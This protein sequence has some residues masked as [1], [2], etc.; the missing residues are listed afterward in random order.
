MASISTTLTSREALEAWL[1]DFHKTTASLNAELTTDTF[2]TSDAE[3][4][5]GNFPEVKGRDAVLGMFA[6]AFNNL[7]LMH[8]EIVNFDFVG[9]DKLY[10]ST[11]IKYVIKGDDAEKDMITIPAILSAW[12]KEDE[13]KPKMQ[14]AEIYLDAS[15]VFARMG[16]KGLL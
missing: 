11:T 10:Q 5:Y 9:P 3:L 16:E 4:Q 1:L 15:Q 13:G 2:F 8:H 12:L 6:P 7:D 14:R